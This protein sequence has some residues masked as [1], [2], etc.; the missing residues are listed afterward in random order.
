[1][2][3]AEFNQSDKVALVSLG[4]FHGKF[5]IQLIHFSTLMLAI[6]ARDFEAVLAC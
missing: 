1:M 5:F 6:Q 4:I 2:T 3:G